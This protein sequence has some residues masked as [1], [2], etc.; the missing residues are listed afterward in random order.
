MPK[1][2]SNSEDSKLSFK[3]HPVFFFSMMQIT[4]LHTLTFLIE[5]ILKNS[6]DVCPYL[7]FYNLICR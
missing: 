1:E 2:L 7:S 6:R 3:M 4:H 5:I